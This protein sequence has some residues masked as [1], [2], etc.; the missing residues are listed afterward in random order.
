[1]VESRPTD[2]PGEIYIQETKLALETAAKT[3]LGLV[4]WT[5][6][7]ILDHGGAGA[8]VAWK[9]TIGWQASKTTLGSNKEIFNAEL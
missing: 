9:S 4:L 5:D 1:M 8:G 7:S 3:H 6:R 2:F